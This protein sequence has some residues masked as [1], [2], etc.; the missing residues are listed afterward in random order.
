MR[1]V[2]VHC[3]LPAAFLAAAWL[4]G[5]ALACGQPAHAADPQADRLGGHL[6]GLARAFEAGHG[7]KV[8]LSVVR[9]DGRAAVAAHRE[10]EPMAPASN[11]KVLTGAFALGRLG[12]DYQFTTALYRLGDDLLVL[13]SGDPLLADPQLAGRDGRSVYTGLDRWAAAVGAAFGKRP[14]GD[15]V[16][17]SAFSADQREPLE[18]FRHEDWP[19]RQRSRWYCAPVAGVNIHNNCFDVVFIER[20]G[21]IWPVVRPHSRFIRASNRLRRGKRHVWSLRTD[22]DDS[23]LTLSG[24][25]RTATD[26]PLSVAMNHPPLTFARVLAERLAKA[27]VKVAG[28]LRHA[29]LCPLPAEKL[30]RP[31]A[32]TRHDLSAA[33]RRMN[34]SS[35]NMAAE[36]LLLAAGDGTWEG[37]AAIMQRTLSERFDLPD[38]ALTVRDGSG[39]S[40]SNRVTP[41]A[42]TAILAELATRR[43]AA[44]LLR[45]LPYSGMHGTLRDRLAEA[46]YRGRVLAKT[47]FLYGVVGLS[48][49]VLDADYRPVY[50]FSVLVNDLPV[51][52][53]AAARGLQDRI[54]STLIDRLDADQRSAERDGGESGGS[55]APAGAG[56]SR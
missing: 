48:G 23:H 26:E 15:I 18:R 3:R 17:C 56:G 12:A 31:L 24:T 19:A 22:S 21:R 36:S 51:K 5:L 33:L 42:M 14:V 40:R 46:P 6:A 53:T 41:A 13:G 10:A 47:G 4:L 44:G 30:P 1:A 20:R 25:V 7:A 27:D 43:E 32:E 39:L 45:S 52:H 34:K 54:A 28:K 37:S 2:P 8:G 55:D 38:G 9:I 29:P 16:V 50:A 49:Y 11:Q 35:L